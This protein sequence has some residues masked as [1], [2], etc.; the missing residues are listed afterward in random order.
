MIV[1]NRTMNTV[2]RKHP[3]EAQCIVNLVAG[4]GLFGGPEFGRGFSV[5][6]GFPILQGGAYWRVW[7]QAW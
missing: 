4:S 6:D 1:P 7:I 2:L 3:A 5:E